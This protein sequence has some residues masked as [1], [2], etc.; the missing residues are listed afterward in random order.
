MSASES[1]APAGG[2]QGLTGAIG[3]RL[4][5]AVLA[6]AAGIA[7]VVIAIELVRSTLG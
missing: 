6:L 5:A 4:A 3:L 7:A 2:R 1:S